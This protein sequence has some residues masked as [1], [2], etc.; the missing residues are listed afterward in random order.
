MPENLA[1]TAPAPASVRAAGLIR[2]IERRP[3]YDSWGNYIGRR[4]I[5][6]CE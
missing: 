5:R 6:V 2:W 1:V 4:R 3:V